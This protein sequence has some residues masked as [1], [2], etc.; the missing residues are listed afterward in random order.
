MRDRHFSFIQLKDYM[1]DGR[2]IHG[3]TLIESRGLLT[4]SVYPV[5][6][7]QQRHKNLE[8]SLARQDTECLLFHTCDSDTAKKTDRGPDSRKQAL[9]GST[10]HPFDVHR[11]LF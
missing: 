6:Y 8:T 7:R 4:L 10:L 1:A 2:S 11:V 9:V 3:F 5:S